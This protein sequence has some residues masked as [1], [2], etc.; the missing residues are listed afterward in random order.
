MISNDLAAVDKIH[1]ARSRI[2][3]RNPFWIM[4]YVRNTERSEFF[5]RRN[6][7]GKY[8]LSAKQTLCKAGISK[9]EYMP[10]KG[11]QQFSI[12]KFRIVVFI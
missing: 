2:F 4:Y 3:D 11:E 12:L 8:K 1:Y 5:L 9:N 10:L 7:I 6:I